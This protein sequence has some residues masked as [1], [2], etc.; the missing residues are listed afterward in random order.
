[1][2]QAGEHGDLLGRPTPVLQDYAPHILRPIPRGTARQR[3]GLD[4]PPPFRGCDLWHAYELSW[5]DA[6]G[7]PVVRVGRLVVPASSP[8]MIESKSL[9]L[10]FNSLNNTRFGDEALVRATMVADLAAVAGA[11]VE[12]QLMGIADPALAGIVLEGH[13]L[14]E[15]PVPAGS[16]EPRA[17]QLQ[18]T[19]TQIV[20]EKLYTHL[21]R[22]LCPVTA[23]PD[24]ATVWLHYRGPAIEHHSLLQYIIAYREHREF[25]EQCVERMFRDLSHRCRPQWLH[26]QAFYTRRGGLDI[27]P[28]RSTDAAAQPLPRLNRQ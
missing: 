16:G 12:L 23:Q 7:K 27:N 1:M 19:P 14:D 3:L 8:N 10:Y 17:E 13:C 28:F 25:H 22:S 26:I 20:E 18:V 2:A 21:L 6:A 4:E 15:L 9:K 11:P 5:L 24:W